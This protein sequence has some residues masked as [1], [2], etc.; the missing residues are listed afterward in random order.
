MDYGPGES[1]LLRKLEGKTE[2]LAAKKPSS[3]FWLDTMLRKYAAQATL[4]PSV[5]N[6]SGADGGISTT[7]SPESDLYRSPISLVQ[8]TDCERLLSEVERLRAEAMTRER[9]RKTDRRKNSKLATEVDKLRAEVKRLRVEAV[10]REREWE[11]DR[12][13]NA[14]LSAEVEK[15]RPEIET[16]RRSDPASP[17]WTITEKLALLRTRIAEY[18]SAESQIVETLELENQ[19]AEDLRP[20]TPARERRRS[21]GWERD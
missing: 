14:E 16:M 1:P 2:P 15:L 18:K 20:M 9:A 19:V 10:T 11:I 13:K 6:P 12:W 4:A 17:N 7:L 8:E 21:T 5:L 3:E